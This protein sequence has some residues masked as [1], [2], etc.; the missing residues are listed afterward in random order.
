MMIIII[1]INDEETW[2]TCLRDV[3]ERRKATVSPK[4][5][6]S[7]QTDRPSAKTASPHRRQT[8]RQPKLPVLTAD[9]QTVSRK[10]QSSPQTDRASAENANPHRKQSVSR[11]CQS[12]P[13]TDRPSAEN[14]TAHHKQTDR[15]PKMPVLIANIH[16]VSRK[17]QSSLQTDRPSAENASPHRAMQ[18]RNQT[19][20]PHDGCLQTRWACPSLSLGRQTTDWKQAL[21]FEVLRTPILYQLYYHTC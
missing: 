4:C 3:C 17:C 21:W 2:H 9:R 8:D 20:Q 6:S 10:C 18:I 19:R 14:A 5:Q 15:R 7:P 12:S 16:T 11:K 1:T 13:Q